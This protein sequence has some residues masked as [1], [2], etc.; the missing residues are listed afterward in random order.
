MGLG[1]SKNFKNSWISGCISN[2]VFEKPKPPKKQKKSKDLK[3]NRNVL[4]HRYIKKKKSKDTLLHEPSFMKDAVDRIMLLQNV[5]RETAIEILKVKGV[6]PDK[7][8]NA[9]APVML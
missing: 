3:S 7:S 8:T 6:F 4:S 2:V 1:N 9:S 5:N